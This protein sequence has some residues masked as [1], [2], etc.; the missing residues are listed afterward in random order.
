MSEQTAR[1]VSSAYKETQG[2]EEE[3]LQRPRMEGFMRILQA[4]TLTSNRN[5]TGVSG[6]PCW[7]PRDRGKNSLTYIYI[8][9]YIGLYKVSGQQTC[10][11][12]QFIS[13]FV[14]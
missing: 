5:K 4:K 2:R 3:E 8:Y 9:I 12:Y 10:P 11:L 14:V 13:D 7:T 1:E 6:R